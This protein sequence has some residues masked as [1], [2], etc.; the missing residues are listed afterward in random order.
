MTNGHIEG[1]LQST[2]HRKDGELRDVLHPV[3]GNVT[4]PKQVMK[5]LRLRPGL[6]Q[7]GEPR[8][9]FLDRFE[10]IEG[11][12][13]DEYQDRVPLYDGTALD[14]APQIKLEHNPAEPTTRI[15]D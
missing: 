5:Q 15:I 1:I 14:P 3:R 2:D 8:G 6:L 9:R 7:R 10:S 4:V 13:V 12:T 11:H